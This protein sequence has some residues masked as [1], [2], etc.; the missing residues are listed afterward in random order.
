MGHDNLHSEKL[1]F[2]KRTFSS[3]RYRD[4]RLIWLG[5]LTEHFG[6]YMET[7]ATAWLLKELTDSPL[8][9]GFLALSK[10]APLLF[11]AIIGGVVTD[12]VDRRK[13]LIGCLLG[14]AVLS[15]ALLILVQTGS[16]APWHLLAASALSAVLMGFN[17]PARGAI[18]PNVTPREEW[19]NA[20]ALDTI[21][22]RS[23]V[24]IAAPIT[25]L[26]ISIYGTMPVFGARAVGMVLAIQWLVM[27]RVPSTP[28]DTRKEA[29]WRNFSKGMKYAFGDVLVI[30][31]LLMFALR[32]FQAETST[33]FLP[34]FADDI[35]G[36]GALG[37]GYLNAAQGLGSLVGLFG[38]ATMG[39]YRHKG[40]LIIITGLFTGIFLAAFALSGWLILS[41]LFLAIANGFGT[42]FENVS[43]ASLQTIVPDEMR[44][45][46]MSLREAVRGLFGPAVSYAL[47]LGGE[48]LGVVVAALLLGLFLSASVALAAFLLPSFRKL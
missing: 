44:G 46:V 6:Q 40:W 10:V 42:T 34:F 25:G 37:F 45:R 47:G 38:I 30:A 28:A 9:L 12:R 2:W 5:S 11:F 8:Y 18:I 39:N 35:L 16:I 17:H 32:E 43:R 24:L 41:V 27:A 20:I 7:M 4:Y 29:P 22:V 21:S 14:G 3:L 1:P 31:L 23:A 15:L 48:Y 19:M 13:L 36:V 26:I 33:I